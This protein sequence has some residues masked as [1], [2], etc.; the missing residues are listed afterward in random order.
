[1]SVTKPQSAGQLVI[2]RT[3]EAEVLRRRIAGQSFRVIAAELGYSVSGAYDAFK[4][5]MA[6]TVA[7]VQEAA[8]E[9][10]Q[11]M[12]ERLSNDLDAIETRRADGDPDAIRVHL[13]IVKAIRELEGLDAPTQ[14]TGDLTVNY[15]LVSDGA[16][17]D[18]ALT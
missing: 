7:P 17:D 14:I 1:M 3:K 18:G 15:R 8:D 11:L 13:Q 10:R 6:A 5:A 2:A 9:L 4:R 16:I 12:R